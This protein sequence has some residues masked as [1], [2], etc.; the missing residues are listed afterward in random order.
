MSNEKIK[1][2]F[3]ITTDR[4]YTALESFSLWKKMN[5]M[6][7]VNEVGQEV[8]ERNVELFR[9]YWDF[10]HPVLNATY[11]SFIID[12]AIFFDTE[13]Y[14]NT[15]S[16]NKLVSLL[17]GSKTVTEHKNLVKEID[18]IKK[19]H[20]VK[21]SLV[22]ELRN[23]EVSHQEMERKR[24][25]IIYKDI[26]E[27]FTAVQEILNLIARCNDGSFTVWDHVGKNTIHSMEWVL[28]NLV[29]GE[30]H[31]LREIDDEMRSLLS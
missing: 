4:M 27:L 12:L 3:Q 16:L 13:K 7:N 29:R 1:N 9:K 5:Q 14:K 2:L 26:E 25:L 17:V 11:K 23:A 24:R 19:K 6:M 10:F 22:L 28:E 30:K 15:F 31:R 20:G 18:E 8:A 21:I